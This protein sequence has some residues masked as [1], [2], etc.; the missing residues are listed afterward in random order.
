MTNT[1]SFTINADNESLNISDFS[2][3][4]GTLKEKLD[5]ILERAPAGASIAVDIVRLGS[6]YQI[7]L[8]LISIAL[9]F[10]EAADAKSPLVALDK[11]LLRAR[12]TIKVWSIGKIV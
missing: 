4:T 9:E 10:F 8:R 6:G 11:V 3:F 2:A 7:G 12:E 1:P 5:D